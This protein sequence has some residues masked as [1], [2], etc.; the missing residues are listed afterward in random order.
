MNKYFNVS[1]R[2]ILENQ[3]FVILEPENTV[4]NQTYISFEDF[5]ELDKQSSLYKKIQKGQGILF[6]PASQLFM[7]SFFLPEKGRNRID[8]IVRVKFVN[9]LPLT[10]NE[11]YYSY[12]LE[13]NIPDN[14]SYLVICFAVKRELIDTAYK[15]LSEKKIKIKHIIPLPLLF[16][17]YHIEEDK[18]RVKNV[19]REQEAIIFLDTYGNK[20]SFTVFHPDGVYLRTV[21]G[22]NLSPELKNTVNYLKEYQQVARIRIYDSYKELELADV[23][24]DR[25]ILNLDRK[26]PDQKIGRKILKTL[27]FLA[28]L[29]ANKKKRINGYRFSIALLIFLIIIVNIFSLSLYIKQEN[30]KLVSLQKEMEELQ[31]AMMEL[32]RIQEEILMGEKKGDLYRGILEKKRSYLSSLYQLSISL[33]EGA[34]INQLSFREDKLVLLN[35]QAVSATRVMEALQASSLFTNLEFIGGIVISGEG[36]GFRIAGDIVN[37]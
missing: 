37:D 18:E 22:E 19:Y 27:D 34:K 35:G 13:Q 11:L 28:R 33:P 26:L 9:K 8:E 5:K 6:V 36:E 21:Q 31:T 15:I 4:D 3:G 29:P 17:F 16:Y 23:L 24:T 10:E 32:D 30:E 25:S 2:L 12:F 7:D 14:G 20:I 1:D